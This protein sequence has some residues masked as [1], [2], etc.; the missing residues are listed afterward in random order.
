MARGRHRRSRPRLHH[1][2]WIGCCGSGI[3]RRTASG[4]WGLAVTRATAAVSSGADRVIALATR[5]VRAVAGSGSRRGA[6]RRGSDARRVRWSCRSRS[7]RGPGA[8]R[9]RTRPPFRRVLGALMPDGPE[10][11][12]LLALMLLRS[13][14]RAAGGDLIPA[15]GARPRA[16]G[17]GADSRMRETARPGAAD[18][19]GRAIPDP[20]CHRG[21]PWLCAA[22]SPDR[23]AADRRPLC[24]ASASGSYAGRGP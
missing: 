20:G 1:G 19:P 24:G 13:A 6:R 21:L 5:S 3:S 10:A 2:D 9:A 22:G 12:G 14:R 11:R 8:G 23:L 4:S 18:G 7:A 15:G 17:L 16:V